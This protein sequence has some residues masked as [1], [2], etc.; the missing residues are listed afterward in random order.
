M[1][2]ARKLHFWLVTLHSSLYLIKQKS[3]FGNFL[4]ETRTKTKRTPTTTSFKRNE[5]A[6]TSIRILSPEIFW[7]NPIKTGGWHVNV[8]ET[9]QALANGFNS[10]EI[11]EV[12][13]FTT[14]GLRDKSKLGTSK[15]SSSKV[16]DSN[17]DKNYPY[18]IIHCKVFFSILINS[19][20]GPSLIFL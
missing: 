20:F 12:T 16:K 13:A 10:I 19:T 18:V 2:M 15:L 9:R 5:H 8:A 4:T 1:A 14:K 3:E 11:G 17:E 6:S 7:L